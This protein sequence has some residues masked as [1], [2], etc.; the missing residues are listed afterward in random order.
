MHPG[1]T[2]PGRAKISVTGSTPLVRS[3]SNTSSG[4]AERGNLDIPKIAVERPQ[5]LAAAVRADR[6]HRP[7]DRPG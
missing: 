5:T 2:A 4:A 1:P 6:W 3:S 7:A